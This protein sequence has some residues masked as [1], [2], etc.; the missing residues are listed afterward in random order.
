MSE[1]VNYF[2]SVL[3]AVVLGY[4]LRGCL[5]DRTARRDQVLNNAYDRTFE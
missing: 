4:H 2:I 5:V 3:L 1:Q